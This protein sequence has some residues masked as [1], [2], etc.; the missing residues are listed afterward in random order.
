MGGNSGYSSNSGSGY[1]GSGSYSYGN[2]SQ[3]NHW[4]SRGPSEASGGSYHYSNSNG[5]YYYQTPMDPP[6]TVTPVGK[7]IIPLPLTIQEC[8]H[9]NVNPNDCHTSLSPF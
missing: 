8:L 6:T 1:S 9:P 2:N 3:G 5:S 7:A 4:C